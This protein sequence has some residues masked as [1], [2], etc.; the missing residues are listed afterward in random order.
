MALTIYLNGTDHFHKCN[1]LMPLHF[2]GLKKKLQNTD[3]HWVISVIWSQRTCSETTQIQNTS[4]LVITCQ[5][6]P[7]S[8]DLVAHIFISTS[9][10]RNYLLWTKFY[11][12]QQSQEMLKFFC[13]WPL[14]SSFPWQPLYGAVDAMV[15]AQMALNP[16]QA[17]QTQ[18]LRN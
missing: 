5:S 2:K 3:Y 13:A 8:N 11:T 16:D 4:L 15:T 9:T 14:H 7:L 18:S 17:F 1:H 12:I 6:E 10:C